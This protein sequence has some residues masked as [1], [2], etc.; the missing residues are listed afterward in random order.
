M[1][2]LSI[3][4]LD[5]FLSNNR[6][7]TSTFYVDKNMYCVMIETYMTDT[8]ETFILRIPSKYKI[9]IGRGNNV[10]NT[11]EIDIQSS[12][13]NII[14]RY[15]DRKTIEETSEYD[16][17]N[18]HLDTT[19]NIE[20]NIEDGYDRPIDI[21]TD[22][23]DQDNE[24]YRQLKR[25]QP[26]INVLRYKLCIHTTDLMYF[27]DDSNNI[28]LLKIQ[29]PQTRR[30]KFRKLSVIVDIDTLFSKISTVNTDIP[31][32][33]KNV[34]T[35]IKRNVNKNIKYNIQTLPELAI[36]YKETTNKITEYNNRILSL[37]QATTEVNNRERK[38]IENRTTLN[39]KHKTTYRHAFSVN[40]DIEH[41]KKLRVIN[42]QLHQIADT[43]KELFMNIL[44]LRH[45]SNNLIL[46]TDSST[47]DI[48]VLSE[49][50]NK[51][52]KE[53]LSM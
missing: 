38:V 5:I 2:G 52:V 17:L 1:P 3:E 23:T 16:E 24:I 42:D 9:Q 4:K 25:L 36:K 43:R 39:E 21:K 45:K 8:D 32:I 22:I 12:D 48:T 41:T 7:I 19:V 26:S 28:R 18:V 49:T 44:S 51:K 33:Y 46:K 53:I 14:D 10:Y 13:G 15:V 40:K 30:H 27:I 37:Q 29:T 31:E 20:T 6:I 50:I 47:F 35:N 34:I 11:K